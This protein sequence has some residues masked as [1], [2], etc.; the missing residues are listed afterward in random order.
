MLAS[1]SREVLEKAYLRKSGAK[2]LSFLQLNLLKFFDAP[3]PRS[4]GDVMRFMGASFAAASKAVG[5]LK[6]K[7]L[8]RTS[9]NPGDMRA[10]FVALTS[11]GKSTIQRYERI[12]LD[13]LRK[14]LEGSDVNRWSSVLEEIVQKLISDREFPADLCMQCGVY[15]SDRCLVTDRRCRVRAHA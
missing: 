9:H 11:K 4:I 14:L 2:D 12:K 5:R 15:Y 3:H 8:V 1:L 10:Q 13:R 7:G 6:R